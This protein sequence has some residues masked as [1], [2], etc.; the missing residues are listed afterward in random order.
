MTHHRSEFEQAQSP[1]QRLATYR[2]SLFADLWIL[3]VVLLPGALLVARHGWDRSFQ[4]GDFFLLSAGVMSAAVA[5]TII[6]NFEAYRAHIRDRRAVLDLLSL[7]LIYSGLAGWSSWLFLAAG[8]GAGNADWLQV[9][10][11]WLTVGFAWT[12]R[13]NYD[14]ARPW[15]SDNPR[16]SP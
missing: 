7:F 9:L 2:D 6:E 11:F 4:D 15:T 14:A 16:R 3:A 8:D 1:P 10:L 5:E 12:L 13:T